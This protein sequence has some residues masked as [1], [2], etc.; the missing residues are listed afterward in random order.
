M[1]RRGANVEKRN[2]VGR[3]HEVGADRSRCGLQGPAKRPVDRARV[4]EVLAHQALD[5]LTRRGTGVIETLRRAF[6][7][8]MGQDVVMSLRFEVQHRAHS[9]HELFGIVERARSGPASTEDSTV[10][11]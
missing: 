8:L 5:A 3:P 11:F 1:L 10:S 9:L 7:E 6:L 4:P 2:A